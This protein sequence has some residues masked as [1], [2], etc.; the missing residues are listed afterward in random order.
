MK[1]I[2]FFSTGIPDPNQ[3]GSGIFNYHILKR[4]IE[5]EY[6][7]DSYFRVSKSFIE[8]NTNSKFLN[9]IKNKLNSINFIYE[10]NIKI[11]KIN[12]F[13]SHLSEI[14]YFKKRILKKLFLNTKF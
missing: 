14:H 2:G 6:F 10:D 11:R 9:K 12:F 8:N 13:Y 4:L 7:V 5:K 3:G 1:K